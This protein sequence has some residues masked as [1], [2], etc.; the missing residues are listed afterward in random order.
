MTSQYN[1]LIM[2]MNE[3]NDGNGYSDLLDA[4]Q[5]KMESSTWQRHENHEDGPQRENSYKCY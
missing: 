4:M 2:F 3:D 1:A 5:K